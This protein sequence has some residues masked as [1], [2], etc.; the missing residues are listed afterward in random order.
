MKG[1]DRGGGD[2]GG[3]W[4]GLA[5]QRWDCRSWDSRV[6]DAQEILEDKTKAAIEST[7]RRFMLL[8]NVKKAI[9]LFG[10]LNMVVIGIIAIRISN[11]PG[12]KN[13]YSSFT[14]GNLLAGIEKEPRW[15]LSSQGP[16][17]VSPQHWPD[18]TVEDLF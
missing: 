10:N 3:V 18:K 7:P 4:A 16:V 2:M 6:C 11:A 15:Y 13:M 5:L 8:Q 12:S 14:V 17:S 9:A 1:S